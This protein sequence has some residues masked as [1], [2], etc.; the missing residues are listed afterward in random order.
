MGTRRNPEELYN[1]ETH[2]D[3]NDIKD[4]LSLLLRLNGRI[5]KTI[6][7]S[8]GMHS[9]DFHEFERYRQ[10]KLNDTYN[11][12]INSFDCICDLVFQV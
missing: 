6:S 5:I 3:D 2:Y 1:R 9:Y 7:M 11:R 4:T 10:Q 12:C 8:F